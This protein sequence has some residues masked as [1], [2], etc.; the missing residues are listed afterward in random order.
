MVLCSSSWLSRLSRRARRRPARCA[1][2]A[3]SGGP[4]SAVT[5]AAGNP[6]RGWC[7]AEPAA[8]AQPGRLLMRRRPAMH[9]RRGA[10]STKHTVIRLVSRH[11]FLVPVLSGRTA[12]QLP[13][14]MLRPQACSPVEHRGPKAH[15]AQRA[16]H[17]L[18]LLRQRVRLLQRPRSAARQPSQQ[19]VDA[20]QPLHAPQKHQGG[21]SMQGLQTGDSRDG[22]GACGQAGHGR[23]A[24]GRICLE[25][26]PGWASGRQP[27]G[28]RECAV[29][30]P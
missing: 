23:A 17:A 27:A 3:G 4:R 14:P 10:T 1:R 15:L 8:C 2:R 9:R 7:A 5:C 12:G 29:G 13:G 26:Q 19:S 18:Q 6:R 24:G 21:R 11:S 25:G 22:E 28:Q 20:G 30:G 16:Q